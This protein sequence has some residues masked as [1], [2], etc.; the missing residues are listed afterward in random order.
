MDIS[1][2]LNSSGFLA[3]ESET[4]TKG[5]INKL[6]NDEELEEKYKIAFFE[7]LHD[8][9]V[10]IHSEIN[11]Y[12]YSFFR[13][14]K[15]LGKN[16]IDLSKDFVRIIIYEKFVEWIN[17]ITV[18]NLEPL[19]ESALDVD[20]D[21]DLRLFAFQELMKA[22]I[23]PD[24]LNNPEDCQKYLSVSSLPFSSHPELKEALMSEW[25]MWSFP[26][27]DTESDI[28]SP[29]K[30]NNLDCRAGLTFGIELDKLV[31]THSLKEC[32]KVNKPTVFDAEF[33]DQFMPGGKTIP[34]SACNTLEG[35]DEYFHLP[36]KF[37]HILDKFALI[38][39]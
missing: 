22:E 39:K 5:F 8:F 14:N 3:L 18:I 33:Y 37:K 28:L 19:I 23:K 2:Y 15:F 20:L 38:T 4:L 27:P 10:T 7:H 36:N 26:F 11:H 30:I 34:L 9:N 16:A 25:P 24:I 32:E 6:L 1:K 29:H 12:C 21:S 13:K 17:A 31:Y 35:F